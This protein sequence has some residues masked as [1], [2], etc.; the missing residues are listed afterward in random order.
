MVEPG[1][2]TL[3]V[4]V[5]A[6]ARF[7]GRRGS[8]QVQQAPGLMGEPVAD[9]VRARAFDQPESGEPA[10]GGDGPAVSDPEP[11]HEPVPGHWAGRAPEE[12]F[13]REG[14]EGIDGKG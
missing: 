13:L 2:L 11:F 4:L 3:P 7:R 10:G 9:R 12:L 6:A 1:R 5:T 14:A 8:G